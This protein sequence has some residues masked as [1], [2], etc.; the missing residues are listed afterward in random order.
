MSESNKL[1]SLLANWKLKVTSA[2]NEP[3][4][5]M[6]VTGNALKT[7]LDHVNV[8]A[9]LAQLQKDIKTVKSI[10]KRD[11]MI[12]QIKYLAGL[13]KMGIP[14]SEAYILHNMPVIPPVTRPPLQQAGNRI[15]YPDVNNLYKD[16]MIVNMAL[17][18][19]LDP[20]VDAPDDTLMDQ[21]KDAYNSVKAVFGL[22]EAVAGSSRGKSLR[23]FLKQISG[24]KEPGKEGGPKTGFFQAKILSKKQDFSGRATIYAEPNLGF[25]EMAVPEEMLW[26]LYEF[27]IIRDLVKN[28]YTYP[29]ARKAVEARTGP[30]KASYAK[31]IKHIPI[32]AN[33]APTLMQS[34]ITAHFPV[35]VK[36]KTLG[37]NPLHLPMYAGDFDGDAM[38]IHLPI[39]PEAIDEAKKKLLPEHHIYDFREGLGRSL[40]APGHEAIIG[41]MHL[42]EPDMSQKP[43]EFNN[44]A[45][46][47]AALKA[48]TVDINTP[49]KIKD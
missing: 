49:V 46:V 11:S 9:Q 8:D 21:R 35:P 2:N 26:T 23:G 28:G 4:E 37:I 38:T 43:Q 47:M 41:S 6:Q 33:R 5:D 25:N 24:T 29:E 31:L 14:A 32:I 20:E 22:G 13:R 18:E 1:T 7:M 45:E 34:N 30:A 36:G 19:G 12:Q 40:V 39:T 15:E 17:Q 44:E 27:H 10:S 48:G 42:T 3:V 16:H